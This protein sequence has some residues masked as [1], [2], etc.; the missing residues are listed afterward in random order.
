MGISDDAWLLDRLGGDL[1]VFDLR[2]VTSAVGHDHKIDLA[3]APSS[4]AVVLLWTSASAGSEWFMEN[5][6]VARK[7]ATGV[8]AFAEHVE[9]PTFMLDAPTVDITGGRRGGG[10]RSLQDLAGIVS[11]V[12]SGGPAEPEPVPGDLEY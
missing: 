9:V 11:A 2:A 1:G 4:A 12:A 10:A 3:L 5:V 6:E 8:S 7:L